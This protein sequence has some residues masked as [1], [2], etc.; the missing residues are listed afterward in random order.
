MYMHTKCLS[1]Q[2]KVNYLSLLK[3]LDVCMYVACIWWMHVGGYN[4]HT[5]THVLQSNTHTPYL[6][7]YT[8]TPY[9]KI[10]SFELGHHS[11]YSNVYTPLPQIRIWR[12]EYLF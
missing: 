8:H 9:L 7:L 10:G 5:Y 3:I 11:P 12:L 2:N 4:T 6:Y 1:P